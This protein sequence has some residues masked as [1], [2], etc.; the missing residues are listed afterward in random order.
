[1]CVCCT[2]ERSFRDVVL[3]I[4]ISVY[5]KTFYTYILKHDLYDA[6]LLTLKLPLK[7]VFNTAVVC[8]FI[9]ELRE[10]KK[11]PCM[12][13]YLNCPKLNHF[14]SYPLMVDDNTA[15]LSNVAHLNFFFLLMEVYLYYWHIH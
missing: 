13:C 12:M 10:S 14:I 7:I 2:Y 3:G 15:Y 11:S 4:L 1:M 5:S 8:Q 6:N 9:F